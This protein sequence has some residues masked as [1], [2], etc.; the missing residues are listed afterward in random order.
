M[1]THVYEQELQRAENRRRAA[2]WALRKQRSDMVKVLHVIYEEVTAHCQ[3]TSAF[4]RTPTSTW[5]L[6]VFGAIKHGTTLL[7]EGE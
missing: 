3:E 4:A 1:E 2:E 5:V 6:N 7:K